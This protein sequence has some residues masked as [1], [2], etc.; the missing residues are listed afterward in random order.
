[1]Q[2]FEVRRALPVSPSEVISPLL[3]ALDEII[4][5]TNK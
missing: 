2:R 1:L 4:K 5:N 3:P